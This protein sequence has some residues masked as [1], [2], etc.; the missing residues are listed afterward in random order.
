MKLQLI[1]NSVVQGPVFDL[2]HCS[3]LFWDSI[4]L[5]H[6]S[7]LGLKFLLDVFSEKKLNSL[8]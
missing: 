2:N 3:L 8:R 4:R 7:A 1:S 6:N 5:W